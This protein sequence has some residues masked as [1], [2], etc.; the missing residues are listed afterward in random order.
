MVFRP[1]IARFLCLCVEAIQYFQIPQKD[2][3]YHDIPGDF[4]LWR[5]SYEIIKHFRNKFE[6]EME[7]SFQRLFLMSEDAELPWLTYQHFGNLVGNLTDMIVAEQEWQPMI[8][9][10][11]NNHKHI[12]K[13]AKTYDLDRLPLVGGLFIFKN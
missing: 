7:W 11:W 4:P 3:I 9:E 5:L 13:I 12:A 1:G 6:V 10:I 2:G 8:D